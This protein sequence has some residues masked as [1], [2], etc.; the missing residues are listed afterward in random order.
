ML[1]GTLSQ[2]STAAPRKI[3]HLTTCGLIR[4]VHISPRLWSPASS[5]LIWWS[6]Y[7]PL[8]FS[9]L[10][11][12]EE[13]DPKQI[14]GFIVLLGRECQL[15]WLC[16]SRRD[17]YHYRN[18]VF[19]ICDGCWLQGSTRKPVCSV[20]CGFCICI[21]LS[22]CPWL[23]SHLQTAP[24]PTPSSSTSSSYPPTVEV[25]SA[26]HVTHQFLCC[27]HRD[28]CWHGLC[29]SALPVGTLA[30]DWDVCVVSLQQCG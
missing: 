14:E 26:I 12:G 23:S 24:P 19:P 7:V 22:L 28:K 6:F 25:F 18:Q 9:D 10:W 16:L 15:T 21:C 4:W 1:Y 20:M 5:T 2:A 30:N 8:I 13:P 11:L 3:V 27:V 17:V 29:G